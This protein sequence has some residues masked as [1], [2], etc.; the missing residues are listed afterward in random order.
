MVI[1]WDRFAVWCVAAQLGSSSIF[2]K[3]SSHIKCHQLRTVDCWRFILI[4]PTIIMHG[5]PS[6]WSGSHC[7]PQGTI[8]AGPHS[9]THGHWRAACDWSL[10]S[11]I[12]R[13]HR[14]QRCV[15]VE[16]KPGAVGCLGDD[17]MTQPCFV[18]QNREGMGLTL[19]FVV[20]KGFK[21]GHI[22]VHLSVF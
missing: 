2:V 17:A 8:L 5:R 22:V 15:Q 6:T 20:G 12:W 16:P 18:L 1:G 21:W 11:G 13:W 3:E 9:S 10:S 14:L 4:C 19:G 7:I